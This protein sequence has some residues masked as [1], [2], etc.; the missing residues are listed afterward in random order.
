[1]ERHAT[2]GK[3]VRVQSPSGVR[4]SLTPQNYLREGMPIFDIPFILFGKAR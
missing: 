4:I 1:M 2:A 3:R